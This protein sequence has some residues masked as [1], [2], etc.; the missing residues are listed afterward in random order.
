MNNDSEKQG[1]GGREHITVACEE[2]FLNTCNSSQ[3]IAAHY[4]LGDERKTR[5][6]ERE[7]EKTVNFYDAIKQF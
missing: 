3:G 5:G 4:T 2:L 6:K 7:R 1:G